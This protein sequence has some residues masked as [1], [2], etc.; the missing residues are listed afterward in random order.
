MRSLIALFDSGCLRVAKIT[1][2]Y[3]K[4]KKVGVILK[5]ITLGTMTVS[6][7]SALLDLL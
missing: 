2:I 1:K 6:F 7:Y 4:K 5:W 3:I